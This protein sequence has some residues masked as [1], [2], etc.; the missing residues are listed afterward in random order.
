MKKRVL[1]LVAV[2]M[3][4]LQAM[5]LSETDFESNDYIR[6]W[7]QLK[8]V[9]TPNSG[10]NKVQLACQD[11][12]AVQLRGWCTSGYQWQWAKPAFDQK[13]DFAGMKKF[14]ANVVRLTCYVA[15]GSINPTNWNNQ[16]TWLKNAITWANELGMYCI[17]DYH[18]LKVGNPD[19]SS[20]NPN[21]YLIEGTEKN[22]PR[23]VAT[24]FFSE[25]SA[26]VK[27]NEY[28]HVIYE[29]CNEPSGVAWSRVKA[30]ANTVLPFI[31][32]ND[33]NAVVIVGTGNYSQQLSNVTANDGLIIHNT[34]QIMYAFHFYACS[35]GFLFNSQFTAAN[36]NKIPVFITEWNNTDSGGDGTCGTGDLDNFMSRINAGGGSSQKVS[37]TSW[38]WD[39]NGYGNQESNA[40][41]PITS[42]IKY[43]DGYNYTTAD[44]KPT[45]KIVYDYLQTGAT[46]TSCGGAS[47]ATAKSVTFAINPNPAKNGSFSVTLFDSGTADLTILNLQGQAVYNTVVNNG[48]GLI[49]TYLTAGVYIVSIQSESGLKTQK[50]VIK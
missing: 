22:R 34:L 40:L 47:V 35:H 29:I 31:A 2:A 18:V 13:S 16:K 15:N 43:G 6:A 27:E 39:C 11:G 12:T 9:T 42:N 46:L 37:W 21:D 48:F 10:E 14:G 28:I 4:A 45:G 26:Y 7:G 8:L 36:L 24:D 30:Y 33:P 32:D 25:I 38:K 5:A 1:L 50:L 44:L 20:G 3:S 17:V 23:Q 19:N 41:L 49:N